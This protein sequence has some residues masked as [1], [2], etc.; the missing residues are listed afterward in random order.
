M[1]ILAFEFSS[2]R[3]SVAVWNADASDQTLAVT[4][5]VES[6]P[7]NTMNPLRMT[8]VALRDAGL[9]REQIECIAIGLGP[10]SYTGIRAA[11]A[12]AQGW[13]LAR[14]V[15]ILGVSS[16]ACI[17]A[18]AQA[19]GLRGRASIVIDAQ[20]QEF[21][22]ASYE[23]EETH[24]R[25]IVPLRLVKPAAVSERER[26]GDL[27]VGPDVS[28]WFP[29]VTV[30]FPNAGTITKLARERSDFVAADRIEP[31][32]LRETTFVKAPPPRALPS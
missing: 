27:L 18:R 5:V 25:E 32:Y 31:I 15:K 10:G 6:A 8:E 16:A 26:A 9:E 22:L 17:A 11:I 29:N 21:Y 1:K 3:R 14:E 13:S 4:E 19:D 20:R 23:L 28:H 30:L 24:A 2:T 12:L 7:R